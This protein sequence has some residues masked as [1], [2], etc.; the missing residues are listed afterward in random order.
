[1]LD[2][3]VTNIKLHDVVIQSSY[4]QLFSAKLCLHTLTTQQQAAVAAATAPIDMEAAKSI[5]QRL[6]HDITAAAAALANSDS[7]VSSITRST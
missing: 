2:V 3:S 6:L 4:S 7:T 5:A 1:M